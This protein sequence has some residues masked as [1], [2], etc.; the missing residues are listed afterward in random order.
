[1][2]SK[3]ERETR[4]T[5]ISVSLN[6][7]DAPEPR[8]DTGIPFF[9]HM[10]TAMSFH[11][12]LGLTAQ[13]RGDVEVDAHHTVEDLG[14]VLGDAVN[15]IR[16][17]DPTIRRFGH[18][19]VPMDD[20]LAEVTIDLGGRPYLVWNLDFPQE[21]AGSFQLPLLREF[22]QGLAIRGRCNL[23][24]N[25]RYGENGHHLAEAVFKALGIALSRALEPGYYESPGSTKGSF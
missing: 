2:K 13:A 18:A 11:G 17:Q 19:V 23:H 16:E 25:G 9:D 6:I 20:A 22:M 14:L 21:Y 10:L 3:R 1:M 8:L 24:V 4:E 5:Q 15:D 12:K 7:A